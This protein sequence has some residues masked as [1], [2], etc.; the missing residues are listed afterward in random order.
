MFVLDTDVIS[1]EGRGKL[2]PDAL[3]RGSELY[4]TVV[5]VAEIEAGV[6]KLMRKGASSKAAQL[7]IW[8]DGLLRRFSGRILPFDLKAAP[9]AG[10]LLDFALGQGVEPDFTDIQIAAIARSRGFTVLTRNARHYAPLGVPFLNPYAE[11]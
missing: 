9:I 8:R 1:D 6:R 4:L 10:E 5:T 11:P 7:G 3:A 2:L